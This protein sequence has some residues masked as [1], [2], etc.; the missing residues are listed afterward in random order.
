MAET[1]D[2]QQKK[3][4]ETTD[5]PVGEILRRTR[6]HYK[7]SLQDVETNLRIRAEQLEALESCD[8][9]RLPGQVYAL[10]FVRTYSEYLG[11][12]GDKMVGLFKAQLNVKPV[13][14][15]SA[16]N[17]PSSE[18]VLPPRWLVIGG[19]LLLLVFVA[20]WMTMQGRERIAVEEIPPVTP[21][22]QEAIYQ[23]PEPV[24]E[25]VPVVETEGGEATLQGIVLNIRENSWVEIRDGKGDK[26]LS[27]VL[28]AGD[29]YFVPD[30]PEL[31]I[32]IGNAGG[33]DLVVDGQILKT[34]GSSG[35][36]VRDMPLNSQE[37]K[38]KYGG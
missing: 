25:E 23:P 35:E 17:V 7:L 34:L 11:L 38:L 21:A 10:G 15:M 6:V 4:L 3:S 32:S 16:P 14:V 19:L 18:A 31:T 26:I 20:I 28:R 37:L 12:D 36:V 24:V 29:Q 1:S 30:R 9:S 13:R 33:V 2:Q 27:R 8:M 22:I 5:I